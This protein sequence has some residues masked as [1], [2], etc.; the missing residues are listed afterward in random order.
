MLETIEEMIDQLQNKMAEADKNMDRARNDAIADFHEGE[1]N[2]YTYAIRL[3][4][5]GEI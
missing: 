5:T 1:I 4:M 2:A 3:L